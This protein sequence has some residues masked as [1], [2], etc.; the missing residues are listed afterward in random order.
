MTKQTRTKQT[1]TVTIQTNINKIDNNKTNKL[2][3]KN[4]KQ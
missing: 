2:E 4:K 3:E 1:T